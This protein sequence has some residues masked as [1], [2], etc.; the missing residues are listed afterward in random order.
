MAITSDQE[1]K[2]WALVLEKSTQLSLP[3]GAKAMGDC[4]V[5]IEAYMTKIPPQPD[6]QR[7]K[8]FNGWIRE[9]GRFPKSDFIPEP[10]G[11][12]RVKRKRKGPTKKSERS[13]KAWRMELQQNESKVDAELRNEA[14][15]SGWL[16][17]TKNAA[18]TPH[19]VPWHTLTGWPNIDD[20]FKDLQPQ[21]DEAIDKQVTDFLQTL[22]E[23]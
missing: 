10:G 4:L 5:L 17:A 1:M 19:Q 2:Q 3:F 16:F 12:F 14:S 13:A 8:T 20:A 23:K 7:A 6:R 22:S 18:V 9:I 11:T 21:L 15:Y